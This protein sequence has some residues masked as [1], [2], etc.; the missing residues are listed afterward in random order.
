MKYSAF[1][2][3][4]LHCNF[5]PF[6]SNFSILAHENKNR[7]LDIEER[8]LIIEDN[9]HYIEHQFRTVVPI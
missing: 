2:D 4:L 6:F 3:H 7:L 5:L 1:C 8:L 9:Y